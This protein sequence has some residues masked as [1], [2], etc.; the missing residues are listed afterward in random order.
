MGDQTGKGIGYILEATAEHRGWVAGYPDGCMVVTW[1]DQRFMET[2]GI[3]VDTVPLA[4][5]DTRFHMKKMGRLVEWLSEYHFEKMH[6]T[7]AASFALFLAHCSLFF[8]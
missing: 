6:T 4:V 7:L 3:M 2:L 5:E 8:F 1:D